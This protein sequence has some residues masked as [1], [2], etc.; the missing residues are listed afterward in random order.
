MLRILF[1]KFSILCRFRC[2][3]K[4][5]P[6]KGQ[7]LTILIFKHC[8]DDVCVVRGEI[9]EK[10]GNSSTAIRYPLEV[11]G[12]LYRYSKALP[13]S[14][15]LYAILRRIVF[16]KLVQFKIFNTVRTARYFFRMSYRNIS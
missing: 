8:G 16:R 1:L 11:A 3:L 5:M 14:R 9:S 10:K 13:Y 7:I 6:V 12:V 4:D 2:F 15:L